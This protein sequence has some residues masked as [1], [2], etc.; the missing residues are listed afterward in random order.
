MKL[1]KV[2]DDTNI[3]VHIYMDSTVGF[4]WWHTYIYI[5]LYH[6]L[7]YIHVDL[8]YVCAICF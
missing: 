2:Y 3:L 1:R 5:W 8:K 4:Q 6:A 7:D